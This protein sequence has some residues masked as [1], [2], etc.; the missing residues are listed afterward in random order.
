MTCFFNQMPQ[1]T[2]EKG[3]GQNTLDKSLSEIMI[4][5]KFRK[6][7]VRFLVKLNGGH[8]KNGYNLKYF[9]NM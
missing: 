7:E 2:S 9:K 8:R 5:Y 4:P 6:E 1:N 3:K